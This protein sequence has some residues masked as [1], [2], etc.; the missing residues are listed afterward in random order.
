MKAIEK[1]TQIVVEVE[2]FDPENLGPVQRLLNKA[3]TS[4]VE[5]IYLGRHDPKLAFCRLMLE[6]GENKRSSSLVL[7]ED[8]L[9][10]LDESNKDHYLFKFVTEEEFKEQFDVI[11]RVSQ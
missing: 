9:V 4:I 11:D 5:T 7:K 3:D 10:V 1:E 8:D 2:R 6:T